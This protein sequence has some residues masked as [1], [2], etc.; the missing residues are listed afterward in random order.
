MK[1]SEELIHSFILSF[2]HS[3]TVRTNPVI[4]PGHCSTLAGAA[5]EPVS[6]LTVCQCGI[7][8][9]EQGSEVT[10]ILPLRPWTNHLKS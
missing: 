5:L 2:I 1:P 3:F 9:E 10:R 8:K 7:T 6:G 4:W